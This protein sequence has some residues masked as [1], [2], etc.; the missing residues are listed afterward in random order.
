MKISS[1]LFIQVFLE[2]IL[3][4]RITLQSCIGNILFS[5]IFS[6]YSQRNDIA[7]AI[8]KYDQFDFLIDIVPREEIKPT[9][10]VRFINFN[11]TCLKVF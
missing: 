7:L 1:F 2:T 6:N 5:K 8:S 11:Q 3:F 9:K 4:P 10:K